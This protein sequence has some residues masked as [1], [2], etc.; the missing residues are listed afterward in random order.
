MAD[1]T[2]NNPFCILQ[3]VVELFGHSTDQTNQTNLIKVIKVVKPTNK[4][5]LL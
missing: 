5:T 3:L 4:K 2:Q 1:D